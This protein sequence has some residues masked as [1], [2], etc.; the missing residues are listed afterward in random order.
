MQESSLS[1]TWKLNVNV[2]GQT[3]TATF[4]FVQAKGGG[5]S[6]TYTGRLGTASVLGS[7]KGEDVEFSFD[8]HAGDVTYRGTYAGGKLSGTCS[9]GA[10]GEGTFEGGRAED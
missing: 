6:G 3:G 8:W 9:Y 7:V 4:E 1:G 5:L 2:G 10:A